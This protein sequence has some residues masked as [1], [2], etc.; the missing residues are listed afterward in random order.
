[1]FE[2][3]F[4]RLARNLAFIF[5]KLDP[6]LS[7][8]KVCELASV[9]IESTWLV[10]IRIIFA[11]WTHRGNWL[12]ATALY[13]RIVERTGN[14]KIFFSWLNNLMLHAE[15]DWYFL[16]YSCH[17][18]AMHLAG[19]NIFQYMW[20]IYTSFYYRNI[21]KGSMTSA[22]ELNKCHCEKI[23]VFLPRLLCVAGD[24]RMDCPVHI[25]PL[26]NFE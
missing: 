18:F 4:L 21:I 11:F 1:M 20:W 15:Y 14:R 3:T 17:Y 8:D 9:I 19:C 23:L 10:S 12:L 22:V 13:I 25:L 24:V 26:Y 16:N 2:F 5:R 6:P 7:L